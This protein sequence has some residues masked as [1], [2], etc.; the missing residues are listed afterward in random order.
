MV[1]IG[2]NIANCS[3]NLQFHVRD[4]PTRPLSR[5]QLALLF[6]RS[7][8]N[9][10]HLLSQV[11]SYSSL[12]RAVGS[13]MLMLVDAYDDYGMLQ[14]VNPTAAFFFYWSYAFF[15]LF[16]TLNMVIGIITLSFEQVCGVGAALWRR[17]GNSQICSV[18]AHPLKPLL[19]PPPPPPG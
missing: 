17:D 16:F 2:K 18:T 4:V 19:Q 1:C 10:C 5:S 7:R 14:A 9:Q 13:T 6:T 8:H 11:Q 12:L 15:I 3:K